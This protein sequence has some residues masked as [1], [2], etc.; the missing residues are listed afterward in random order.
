[1]NSDRDEL[2]QLF[3]AYLSSTFGE[4]LP[5]L[6]N[7]PRG[8]QAGER[9]LYKLKDG[10]EVTRREPSQQELEELRR[11]FAAFAKSTGVDESRVTFDPPVSSGL[12]YP[13]L[14]DLPALV[15]WDTEL[16]KYLESN[17]LL[18]SQNFPL[19]WVV[20]VMHGGSEKMFLY[21][22]FTH[23]KVKAIFRTSYDIDGAPSFKERADIRERFKQ[24]RQKESELE[25]QL[26]KRRDILWAKIVQVDS[27]P[28]QVRVRNKS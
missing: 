6:L 27:E 24:F 13:R 25:A 19:E 22:N 4:E 18:P 17:D 15:M 8:V 23:P 1:V 14:L 20:G 21:L 7:A 28:Q 9:V 2:G 5:Q 16:S 11:K 10:V 12:P 26:E 3:F